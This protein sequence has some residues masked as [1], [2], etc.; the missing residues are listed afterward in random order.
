[1]PKLDANIEST[2]LP[3]EDSILRAIFSQI[4]AEIRKKGLVLNEEDGSFYCSKRFSWKSTVTEFFDA[5][6]KI[7]ERK[8]VHPIF[9]ESKLTTAL[10][11]PYAS[12][13]TINLLHGGAIK[14]LMQFKEQRVPPFSKLPNNPSKDDLAAIRKQ[15]TS[16]KDICRFIDLVLVIDEELR[17]YVSQLD[18]LAAAYILRI[19]AY[20]MAVRGAGKEETIK[21]KYG[22]SKRN[23]ERILA[24]YI[25]K[26][27]RIGAIP[28]S[29]QYSFKALP[30]TD[31]GKGY[32]AI[33]AKLPGSMSYWDNDVL[34]LKSH[35]EADVKRRNKE[36]EK[37]EKEAAK[38]RKREERERRKKARK[39]SRPSHGFEL[40]RPSL[41]YRFDKW[42]SGIGDWF[43][44]KMHD[45]SEWMMQAWI[46]FLAAYVIIGLIVVWV[47]E[48]FFAALLGGIVI[49]FIIGVLASILE[50][51]VALITL[52]VKYITYVPFFILRC[53]FYRAWTFLLFLLGGCGYLTYLILKAKFII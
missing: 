13:D 30:L 27:K 18:K 50:F 10:K 14:R 53:I 2:T 26:L 44:Y 3:H 29:W 5:Y 45:I 21:K 8:Q 4:T 32:L 35:I 11:V 40:S 51:I 25:S 48:G 15:A 52:I 42:V 46:W 36:R 41:Y 9:Q 22:D 34:P 37:A 43:G 24:P 17:E 39:A 38:R 7:C 28:S 49:F 12:I 16:D 1:M 20:S 19:S 47:N 33:M 6:H 23:I 31:E